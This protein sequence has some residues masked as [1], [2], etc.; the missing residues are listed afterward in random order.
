LEGEYFKGQ[1]V[2]RWLD[3]LMILAAA[4]Q[5]MKA[6]QLAARTGMSKRTLERDLVH[7]SEL[8]QLKLRKEG[9]RWMLMEGATLR[10]VAFDPAEAVELL[11]ACRLAVRHADYND[12]VLGM[13]LAKVNGVMPRDAAL[14]RRF[15]QETTDE[16]AGKPAADRRADHLDSLVRAW[17][18]SRKARIDYTDAAG[19]KTTRVVHPYCLEPGS[20]YGHGVYLMARDESSNEVRSFKLERIGAVKVLPGQYRLPPDFSLAEHLRDSWGI[21]SQAPLE[22]IVLRFSAAV[23]WR[24]GE[25]TWHPSQRLRKLTGGAVEMTLRVRGTVEITPWILGWGADVEVLKPGALRDDV[26]G[27][28]AAMAKL[29]AREHKAARAG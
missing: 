12:H 23:A 20:A 11:M 10:P 3:I 13:A 6:S 1:K 27:R 4:P 18:A 14:V 17:I 25:T 19:K 15:V 5:G 9:P 7:M 28:G 16:L 29:Y 21:W 2:V 26:A 8:K 24:A 22:E